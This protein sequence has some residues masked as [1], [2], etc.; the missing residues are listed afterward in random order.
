MKSSYFNNDINY[1]DIIKSNLFGK[2]PLKI[3][4]FGILDGFSLK[5]FADT[6]PKAKI[7]AFDIFDEFN[8]NAAKKEVIQEMFKD[9]KNVSVEYGDF[10]KKYE[11]LSSIDILHIDIAN[12]GDVYKFVIENYLPLLSK[13]GIII[14]EGGSAERDNIEWM[15][16]YN[17]PKIN[18]YLEELNKRLD[19]NV[20][21]IGKVPSITFIKRNENFSIHELSKKD[22]SNGFFELVNYFTKNLNSDSYELALNNINL[23]NNENCKTLVVELDRKIIATGKILMET[24]V[25]NNLR[26]VGHIED[27]IV[28]EKYRNTGIGT[29]LLNKLIEI[30]ESNNCYK[31]ILECGSDVIPFY[32]KFGFKVKGTEMCLYY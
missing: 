15:I 28:D 31:T 4:E 7:K 30:G 26:K 32:E 25:H 19:L 8:G 18:L 13:D 27:V 11:D 17:K 23:F 21:V 20:I 14:L 5:I 10:Y 3:V 6:F 9:Y 29:I 2:N 12:N 22:F 16:K 1:G 24:K